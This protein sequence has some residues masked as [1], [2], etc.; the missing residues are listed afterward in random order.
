MSELDPVPAKFLTEETAGSGREAFTIGVGLWQELTLARLGDLAAKSEE[1]GLDHLWFANHKLYR[2][3]FIG[4]AAMSA[5]TSTIGL[6]TFVAE[7]YSQH[8]AQLAAAIATLDELSGG[9]ATLV[10]GAGGGTLLDIGLQRER[11]VM[12]MR[13]SVEIIRSLLAGERL[14]YEGERFTLR[15]AE[16]HVPVE[17][18][19][20]VVLAARGDGM[21]RLSGRVTDGAMAAPFASADGLSHAR[22]LVERGMAK[23]GR[24]PG[25]LPLFARVD[26]AIDDDVEA[27]RDAV[28]SII[29]MMV[30]ASYP[31]TD[32]LDSVGLK[33]TP[34]LAEM[35]EPKDEELA[36][37]SGHLV[38]DEYVS[39]FAWVGPPDVVAEGI[40]GA[41]KAGFRNLT[42]LPQPL[43]DDPGAAIDRLAH[44]VIPRVARLL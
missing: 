12:V 24:K 34:E 32:F 27:A 25:T 41:V 13:E 3:L 21:L 22:A 30:M 10:M 1:A 15:D 38:P 39:K 28:R 44:E 8:P 17:R 16:L 5:R 36:L 37:S 26:I 7:P 35:S 11:P 6:G 31:N 42:L 23:A 2:D 4:L 18:R 43:T 9:R 40:A 20:P 29:A 14:S 33:L 19:I